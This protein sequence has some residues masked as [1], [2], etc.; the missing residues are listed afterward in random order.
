MIVRK[1]LLDFVVLALASSLAMSADT[2]T[3]PAKLSAGE[4]VDR[5]VSARGGLQANSP[6]YTQGLV[7]GKRQRVSWD[8]QAAFARTPA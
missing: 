2:G 7:K 8:H 4:I 6:D 1:S 5:N 3:A